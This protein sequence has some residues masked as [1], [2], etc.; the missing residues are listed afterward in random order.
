MTFGLLGFLS[1]SI[2]SITEIVE[3]MLETADSSDA[4][5]SKV[6]RM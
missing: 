5:N 1:A 4:L 6:A 3:A 2:L